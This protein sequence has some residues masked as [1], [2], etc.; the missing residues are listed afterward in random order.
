MMQFRLSLN[1]F[2]DAAPG[3]FTS[4]PAV[5]PGEFHVSGTSMPVP[6]G[7]SSLRAWGGASVD[8]LWQ[9]HAF[10]QMQSRANRIEYLSEPKADKL[11]GPVA[12]RR[13]MQTQPKTALDWEKAVQQVVVSPPRLDQL[14]GEVV[15][16][17][18]GFTNALMQVQPGAIADSS[19]VVTTQPRPRLDLSDA[20]SEND[21]GIQFG[22]SFE[23]I[24]WIQHPV[25]CDVDNATSKLAVGRSPVSQWCQ[26]Q[27]ESQTVSPTKAGSSRARVNRIP[28]VANDLCRQIVPAQRASCDTK[29]K[30]AESYYWHIEADITVDDV[31]S[32][33]LRKGAVSEFLVVV[34]LHRKASWTATTGD[35]AVGH[36]APKEAVI[37]NSPKNVSAMACCETFASADSK[38]FS[39]ADMTSFSFCGINDIQDPRGWSMRFVVSEADD[40]GPLNAF[41]QV[42]RF[43][44]QMLWQPTVD[45]SMGV[46]SIDRPPMFGLTI[47]V[48]SAAT[49]EGQGSVD[50]SGVAV[51]CDSLENE[52]VYACKPSVSA[53]AS[54]SWFQW[55]SGRAQPV[56]FRARAYHHIVLHDLGLGEMKDLVRVNY[57]AINSIVPS[58]IER[59]IE[60]DV[61]S[62]FDVATG[63]CLGTDHAVDILNTTFSTVPAF[64][65]ESDPTARVSCRNAAMVIPE[66]PATLPRLLRES[67]IQIRLGLEETP[68]LRIE[69]SLTV[70]DS[71]V[72]VGRMNESDVAVSLWQTEVNDGAAETAAVTQASIY[73]TSEATWTFGDGVMTRVSKRPSVPTLRES[74]GCLDV[75][76]N[77]LAA[78][79]GVSVSH[80]EIFAVSEVI[81]AETVVDVVTAATRFPAARGAIQLRFAQRA[82]NE[83]AIRMIDSF[84]MVRD[85][86]LFSAMPLIGEAA[87]WTVHRDSPI[88]TRALPTATLVF[89]HS[90]T[91]VEPDAVIVAV[92]DHMIDSNM[93]HKEATTE[94][95][96]EGSNVQLVAPAFAGNQCTSCLVPQLHNC[97]PFASVSWDRVRRTNRAAL[98][99]HTQLEQPARLATGFCT[100]LAAAPHSDVRYSSSVDVLGIRQDS[101][102]SSLSGSRTDSRA[103]KRRPAGLERHCDGRASYDTEGVAESSADLSSQV[104]LGAIDE[105]D[106]RWWKQMDTRIRSRR[107]QDTSGACGVITLVEASASVTQSCEQTVGRSLS[108]VASGAVMVSTVTNHVVATASASGGATPPVYVCA[109]V[110]KF[111]EPNTQSSEFRVACS[112]RGYGRSKEMQIAASFQQQPSI[113]TSSF[114]ID[115]VTKLSEPVWGIRMQSQTLGAVSVLVTTWRFVVGSR[116]NL[117]MPATKSAGGQSPG[118]RMPTTPENSRLLGWQE[119]AWHAAFFAS[120][121]L[122]S[123]VASQLRSQLVGMPVDLRRRKLGPTVT[124]VTAFQ[125]VFS[126][127]GRDRESR[128]VLSVLMPAPGFSM[129][130]GLSSITSLAAPASFCFLTQVATGETNPPSPCPCNTEAPSRQMRSKLKP[131]RAKFDR[132]NR[133]RA[134]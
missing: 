105:S 49:V 53:F 126:N 52:L 100:S 30:V 113:E 33:M 50:T 95:P 70:T 37:C 20:A 110:S 29:R 129:L 54:S 116:V 134:A 106:P 86:N 42:I 12:D 97:A 6:L 11:T 63:T 64:G 62:S 117:E 107:H 31:T 58:P 78:H 32:K 18:L 67:S 112:I 133:P 10:L 26:D 125:D 5:A 131:A 94:R 4:M 24:H 75:V 66:R 46:R 8:A 123:F 128:S 104:D 93:Q 15:D 74:A 65:L 47:C 82:V 108:I 121:I 77:A 130:A 132:W 13:A 59:K 40:A 73:R 68:S 45:S 111:L 80:Y 22:P 124:E 76:S 21:T 72:N 122:A 85:T 81:E 71:L 23:S 55:E 3:V 84:A 9:V 61:C 28:V 99:I 25:V 16:S 89:D 115:A 17:A 56:H 69:E 79:T 19:I 48:F 98:A 109:N 39:D 27:G 57:L 83:H 119:L 101:L 102:L 2:H 51:D 87:E 91:E 43:V 96:A 7:S 36:E 103:A 38:S 35:I 41:T 60:P 120:P 14:D 90:V 118:S 34:P 92:L 114:A 127:I 88:P 1:G 44:A